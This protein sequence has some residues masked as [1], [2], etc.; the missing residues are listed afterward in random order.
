HEQKSAEVH[1]PTRRR[2][3]VEATF[4]RPP[5]RT[6]CEAAGDRAEKSWR[7]PV[8]VTRKLGESRPGTPARECSYDFTHRARPRDG[9]G[10][11]RR[12]GPT[13]PGGTRAHAPLEPCGARPP[14]RPR[15]DRV[16][17]GAGSVAARRAAAAPP[18]PRGPPPASV[19]QGSGGGDGGRP[20]LDA[21]S[22]AVGTALGRRAP[23]Q[24]RRL[25]LTGAESGLR[26]QRLRRDLPRAVRVGRKTAPW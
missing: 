25:R 11:G 2:E 23:A 6:E 4:H 1:H 14:R 12:A 8:R 24:L 17:R 15:P 10:N 9:V 13:R 20:P 3:G 22:R 21:D 19:L 5:E 16:T 26:S 18:R 7:E